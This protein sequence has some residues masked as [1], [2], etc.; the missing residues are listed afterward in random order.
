M[1]GHTF[2]QRRLLVAVLAVG[3]YVAFTG[4]L[5][6]PVAARA[7]VLPEC[8]LEC[9]PSA[10]C[11]AG[12]RIQ[13]G[14]SLE[15]ITCGE[16]NG[17]ADNNQCN[18]CDYECTIWSAPDQECWIGGT[19]S[20]CET[21]G[22]EYAY[23]GDGI[24][25]NGAAGESCANC[26]EDC[27]TCPTPPTCGDSY[28]DPGETY[29]TCTIDCDDPDDSDCGDGI[30]SEKN[31]EDAS[32]CAQDCVTPNERCDDNY[33]CP[34]GYICAGGTEPAEGQCVLAAD[35]WLLGSCIP[36]GT[37]S[38]TGFVCREIPGTGPR[39]VWW[40]DNLQR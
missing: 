6:T 32:N 39:C 4:T 1:N 20:D 19:T 36:N 29:R 40:Y 11:N 7:A 8:E 22:L 33:D 9:G 16:Y 35:I 17:G 31:G 34:A 14:E 5:V 10:D 15:D 12:C 2:R 37:C 26:D 23:C 13:V 18:T 25:Q 38:T 28:C 3:L 24:C 21:D 27:N 30:C